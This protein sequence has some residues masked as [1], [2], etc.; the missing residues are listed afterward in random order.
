MD[1]KNS[2]IY[3][4]LFIVVNVIVSVMWYGSSLPERALVATIIVAP[5]IVVIE[6]IRKKRK[7]R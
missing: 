4:F 7:K 2:M 3:I 6:M 5:V 1:Q